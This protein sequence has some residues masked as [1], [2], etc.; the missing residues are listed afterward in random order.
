MFSIVN[1]CRN[2]QSIHLFVSI[3]ISCFLYQSLSTFVSFLSVSHMPILCTCA[4]RT[5]DKA[6]Q[7]NPDMN[8]GYL[9]SSSSLADTGISQLVKDWIS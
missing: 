6:R 7:Y 9:F 2:V 3:L 8:P 4:G 5:G 1:K